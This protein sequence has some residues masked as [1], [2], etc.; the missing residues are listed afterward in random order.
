[1]GSISYFEGVLSPRAKYKGASFVN[2]TYGDEQEAS[3]KL[4]Q[5]KR[6]QL[7]LDEKKMTA[8]L[9]EVEMSQQKAF[10]IAAPKVSD[11][12]NMIKIK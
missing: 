2:I 9:D 1:M 8:Y 10:K 5:L 11:D 12:K 6:E 3:V 7:A 4:D